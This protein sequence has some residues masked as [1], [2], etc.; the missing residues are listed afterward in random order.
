MKKSL[1]LINIGNTHTEF[2]IFDNTQITNH[3]VVDSTNINKIK[4][5]VSSC[6]DPEKMKVVLASVRPE[7]L[8]AILD[9]FVDSSPLI[10]NDTLN[11]GVDCLAVDMTTVGA[12]R[13]ANIVAAIENISLP[14]MVIDC[15]TAITTEIIDEKKRFIGGI[16]LP[17]RKMM[18]KALNSQTGQL[19]DL[20][21][22]PDRIKPPKA[23]GLNTQAAIHAGISHGVIGAVKNII[24]ETRKMLNSPNLNII[25]TGGDR[26]FFIKKLS[27]QITEIKDLTL[28]GMVL[29]AG[30]NTFL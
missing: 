6:F 9:V 15:G 10:I 14:V 21:I 24:V 5:I 2:A 12:D 26:C 27:C 13:I 20:D 17:G 23:A 25:L 7:T 22:L 30:K 28:R 16:I 8:N 4:K 19:P 29:I 11:I 18:Y 3:Q 1:Y